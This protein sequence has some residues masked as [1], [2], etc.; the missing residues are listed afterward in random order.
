MSFKYLVHRVHLRLKAT[1]AYRQPESVLQNRLCVAGSCVHQCLGKKLHLSQ[2]LSLR[3]PE[4]RKHPDF[5]L[6]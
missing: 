2:F 3:T 6:T 4:N 1:T 5:T